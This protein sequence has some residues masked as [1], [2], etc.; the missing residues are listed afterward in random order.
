M[1][2]DENTDVETIDRFEALDKIVAE[3]L[4]F[5]IR[6]AIGEDAYRS[7]RVKNAVVQAWDVAGVAT[8]AA[9]V[10]KSSLVASTFFAPT[11]W[12]AAIGLGTAVTPIGWVV[13]AGVVSGG[14]WYGIT[15]HLKKAT[16]SRVAVVPHFINTPLDVLALGLFDL[17]MPMALKLS[18]AGDPHA[19]PGRQRILDYFVGEWGYDPDFVAAGMA[20]VESQLDRVSIAQLAKTLAEFASQNPDCNFDQMSGEILN[21]LRELS[22]GK[23][24]AAD[25]AALAEV[26]TAFRAARGSRTSRRLRALVGLIGRRST[27]LFRRRR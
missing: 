18:N 1:S 25:D 24:V 3:P 16:A 2:N 5:K 13:A 20:H 6:L 19:A 27:A 17:M 4:R 15:R 8:T 9:V 12:L 7:L 22:V 14:A 23:D 21:F 10:A 26:E 11:G